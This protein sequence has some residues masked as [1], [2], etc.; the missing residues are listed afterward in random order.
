MAGEIWTWAELDDRQ[1]A[2]IIE[3]EQTLGFNLILAYRRTDKS[4]APGVD[5]NFRPAALD[6][7]QLECLLG[8]EQLIGCVAVA[9]AR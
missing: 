3:A 8:V 2:L 5:V 9:Y 1:L 4:H 7:S 6:P